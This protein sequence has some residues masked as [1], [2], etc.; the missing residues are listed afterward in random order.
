MPLEPEAYLPAA[1]ANWD[2]SKN[3]HDK[4]AAGDIL[5]SPILS[6]VLR[7]VLG[8]TTYSAAVSTVSLVPVPVLQR[9]LAIV[10]HS[11]RL[12]WNE[13]EKCLLNTIGEKNQSNEEESK[14]GV[15]MNEA[16]LTRDYCY[17][18]YKDGVVVPIK[19]ETRRR[20]VDDGSKMPLEPKAYLPAALAN[21]DFSKKWHDEEATG[22][23]LHSSTSG[24]RDRAS[25]RKRVLGPTTYSAAVSTVSLVPVPVLQRNLAIVGH[26]RRLKWNEEEKCLL[27][28]IGEKNQSNEEESKRGVGMNEARLTRDY[29]YYFYKDG[30]VVPIKI[31]TRRREV[32]DGS[33]M[34]LEPKAYLPAA[35]AN[36][37]FSKKWHDEEATGDI[38]HSST[39]GGRDRASGRKSELN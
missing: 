4:E 12:K 1:L 6:A 20:E 15:G 17:Y 2:S 35:L 8:P 18:F 34:P 39:S 29:C 31:E 11:R 23:I 22:D 24:G 14:R 10:G 16:R 30:V 37:D 7:G 33:K 21:W 38:L 36:W 13:E 19:I 5:H 26:S 27:N 3:W 32:D 9:N 25:G 28:T